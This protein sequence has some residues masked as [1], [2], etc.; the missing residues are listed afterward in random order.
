MPRTDEFCTVLANQKVGPDIYLL[1]L[2]S[3]KIAMNAR[4]GQFVMVDV[5]GGR[6]GTSSGMPAVRDPLLRRPFSI[7]LVDEFQGT[8]RLLFKVIGRGT[9]MLAQWK[10]GQ[11]LKV[12][13]PLGNGFSL[14]RDVH[15]I[16]VG[17]GLGIA[18]ILFLYS[19]LHER[20]EDFITILGARTHSELLG[21]LD[22]VMIDSNSL[23]LVTEDGSL[24]ERAMV[25]APLKR[26][27]AQGRWPCLV[28]AC[29][30]LPMLKAVSSLNGL[31]KRD[32][33]VSL[34]AFMACGIGLCLGCA[35]ET[36]Y[37]YVH[38]CK[39]GPVFTASEVF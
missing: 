28:Q 36:P 12:L 11:R 9:S 26:V 23:V 2:E 13:G 27:V 14:G 24:G 21:I 6:S 29:G 19:Y 20:G 8:F 22:A 30:P 38:V 39:D 32:V 10:H 4:P 3:P 5:G 15:K 7:A 37:G 33:E 18:P 35:F 31:D 17:G 1:T 34:E 16:I 25:T